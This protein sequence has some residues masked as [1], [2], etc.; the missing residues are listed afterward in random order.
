MDRLT[1]P[2]GPNHF[3]VCGN[4]TIYNRKPQKINRVSY[5]LAKLFRLED[6]QEP[7]AV[8]WIPVEERLPE[9]GEEVQVTVRHGYTDIGY[10]DES[11]E[12]WWASDD[13][14]IMDV[15]A[16]KPMSEPYQPAD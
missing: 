10:Y 3:R 4:K 2:F 1:E 5:A 8:R 16:W 7:Q 15:I 9:G 14:G 6:D 11:R 12:E 13:A